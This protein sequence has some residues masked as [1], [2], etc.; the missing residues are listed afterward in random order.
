MFKLVSQYKPA[1]DQPQAIDALVGGLAHGD[2]RQTLLGVTGSGKTF[3]MANVIARVQR[4]TLVIAHNKTLAAQLCSEFRRFFPE[5]AVEYFVSYYD[6]YQPEAYL[7]RTDTYIEKEAQINDEI[8][9]LR[10][11]STQALLTRRDVI[12][13]ASVS[14][15]YSI[16]SPE[17]YQASM[18][19]ITDAGDT[20]RDLTLHQ[21]IAM[22]FERTTADVTRGTFRLHGDVLE[23]MPMNEETLYRVTFDENHATHIQELDAVTRRH[24]RDL[25]E[26]WV[27]PAKHYMTAPSVRER[28]LQGIREEM[29][30]R[31]E[32]LEAAGKLL[33]AERLSRRTTQD[34]AMIEQ[35]GFCSGIENYSRWFDGRAPGEPPFTLLDFFPKDFLTFID[36]SHVTLPQVSGMLNGDR[37]RKDNLVAFGFRLP[38][39]VDNRPLS[40]AE[41][42][43]R[44]GQRV[45][46]SATPGE[47]EQQ[48][49]T[50]IVEQVIRPTGLVDPEVLVR[51]VTGS[52]DEL[53]QVD[54]LMPRIRER[55]DMGDRVLITT[56]TKKMAEDLSRFLEEQ[57]MRVGYLH[58]DIQTLDRVKILT[59][60]RKGDIDVVVGVNLLR[61]GLDLPEVSL[62]AILDAD[63]EGFLRSETS[64]IQTIGR[65]ARHVR[66]QVVLYA[67]TMTGS[68]RRAIDETE[69]RRTKQLAYNAEH[70][71]SP[72]TVVRDLQDISAMLGGADEG[73]VR[74]ILKI[75]L[76]ADPHEIRDVIE[77]KRREMKTAARDLDFETA[78][79]LRDEIRLL[80]EE[81]AK[82]ELPPKN[83][84]GKAKRTT[85]Q[86]VDPEA[87]V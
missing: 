84:R 38:S 40:G 37:A 30:A 70:G 74:D 11:A 5:N 25:K 35:T 51:P 87:L 52:A 15:I 3:T 18:L 13:V 16:G 45:Y 81:L 47:R 56:L 46:V 33:E 79:I 41:F 43:A 68:L 29:R 23:L 2:E 80:E 83:R 26:V 66:G 31:V 4:P 28:A 14:C 54:D 59:G 62:V 63:K 77:D 19:H 73:D 39:A 60:F 21:L 34:V 36:E 86:E 10:H 71:I 53:G 67:D 6:Y 49:S 69:R 61:E 55:I 20:G 72:Q 42:D 76:T 82:K 9:R 1:G 17:E 64:L 7:P 58:S 27:F 48:T 65:A 24:K 32:E 8:D 12:I 44:I 57:G 50:R 75:E 78:A 85:V 22:Q